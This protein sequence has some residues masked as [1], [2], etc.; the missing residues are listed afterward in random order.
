MQMPKAAAA[1]TAKDSATA[2]HSLCVW[3]RVWMWKGRTGQRSLAGL[4]PKILIIT[5]TL[6]KFILRYAILMFSLF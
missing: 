5:I 2:V 4:I 6:S 3:S 1:A